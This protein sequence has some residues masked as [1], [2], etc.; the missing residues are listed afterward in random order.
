MGFISTIAALELRRCPRKYIVDLPAKSRA[1]SEAQLKG[2]R[3]SQLAVTAQTVPLHEQYYT[4]M[5]NLHIKIF[6][7]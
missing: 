5:D 2:D 6:N 7:I 4:N 1:V 3:I